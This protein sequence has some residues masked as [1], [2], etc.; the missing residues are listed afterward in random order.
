MREINR[1]RE[2]EGESERFFLCVGRGGAHMSVCEFV[3]P[4]LSLS[5][6]HTYTEWGI[7]ITSIYFSF[8]A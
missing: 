3:F 2:R 7:F 8:I 5:H 4:S 6:A 1:D